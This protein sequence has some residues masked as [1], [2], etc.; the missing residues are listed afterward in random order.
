MKR[1]IRTVNCLYKF[2]IVFSVLLIIVCD[3]LSAQ[4]Y[5]GELPE[6]T[7]WLS[8][9]ISEI[10]IVANLQKTQP[11]QLIVNEYRPGQGIAY[12]IASIRGGS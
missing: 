12:P 10:P 7:G 5:L 6:W 3:N 11:N 4:D 1:K 9:K 2:L 8:K